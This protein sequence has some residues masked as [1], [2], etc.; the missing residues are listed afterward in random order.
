MWRFDQSFY[1]VHMSYCSKSSLVCALCSETCFYVSSFTFVDHDS[2]LRPVVE[3]SSTSS[4]H[5]A[6]L[7]HAAFVAN[8]AAQRV[9]FCLLLHLQTP[10]PL[11]LF[12]ATRTNLENRNLTKPSCN[13]APRATTWKQISD[14]CWKWWS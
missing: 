8:L 11:H 9:S 7:Q 13:R 3:F 5:Y 4:S 2:L 1:Y 10:G 14:S 12:G 6:F